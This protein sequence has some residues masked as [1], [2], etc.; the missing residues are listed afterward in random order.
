MQASAHLTA[1]GAP[2]PVTSYLVRIWEPGRTAL[3]GWRTADWCLSEVESVEETIAWARDHATGSPCEV[4][5]I[6]EGD[7]PLRLW[8]AEPPD[9]STTITVP[10]RR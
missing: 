4:L 8:G 6:G 2:T 5:L 1:I 3:Q 9:A 7:A 10:L